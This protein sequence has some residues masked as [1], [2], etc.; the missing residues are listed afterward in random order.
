[1]LAVKLLETSTPALAQHFYI[2]IYSYVS[3][4]AGCITKQFC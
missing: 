4:D 3:G 2:V 1:M